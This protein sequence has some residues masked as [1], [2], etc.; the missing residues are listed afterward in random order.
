MTR[1]NLR[2][3]RAFVGLRY[4]YDCLIELKSLLQTNLY[5]PLELRVSGE[6]ME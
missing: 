4:R 5:N 6:Q 1:R 2:I 3:L